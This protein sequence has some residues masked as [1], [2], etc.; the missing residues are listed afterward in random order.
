MCYL[1][2]LKALGSAGFRSMTDRWCQV[3]AVGHNRPTAQPP[4]LIRP[5]FAGEFRVG[6]EKPV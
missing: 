4:A 5:A 2:T 6:P 3:V 1:S